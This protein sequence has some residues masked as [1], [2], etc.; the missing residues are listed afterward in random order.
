[1][2]TRH[3]AG[4]IRVLVADDSSTMRSLVVEVLSAVPEIAV[5]GEAGDGLQAVREARRLEP[6][7]VTMDVRMPNMDGIE[8][9]RRIM[10]ERPCRII[11]VTGV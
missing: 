10:Q 2:S 9:I 3:A 8:A 5:V 1:M 7:I 4:P 11:V 6:D